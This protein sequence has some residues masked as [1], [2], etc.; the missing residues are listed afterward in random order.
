MH[1]N[2]EKSPA[3]QGRLTM[4]TVT[5]EVSDS[6]D[7]RLATLAERCDATPGQFVDLLCAALDRETLERI[8]QHAIRDDSVTSEPG[9]AR[10][11]QHLPRR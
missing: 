6:T 3:P 8:I 9:V 11:P 5:L 2:Q 1:R 10:I 7:E 4:K